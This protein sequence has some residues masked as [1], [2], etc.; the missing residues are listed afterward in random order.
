MYKVIKN[1]GKTVQ[2][3]QLGSDSSVIQELLRS[4]KIIP[5]DND[6]YEVFSQE[7]L[8]A[9]AEHG[10]I[11]SHGDWIKID[12]TGNPYPND[13]AFFEKNHR[14]VEGDTFEQIPQ[15]FWAWDAECAM[16]KE[17]EFLIREKGLHITPDSEEQ[18]YTAPLWGTVESAK[19]DAVIIFYS[20]SY[21]AAGNVMDADFNF[22]ERG[23]F[24]RTY[25]R[26]K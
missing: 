17:I 18:Y 19:K 13:Q 7:V 26:Y 25:S 6:K 5:L 9:G 14:Q 10:Q 4:R 24:E 15:P 11:A 22:V 1:H 16:C 20:I 3:Y 21:D 2:A 8:Q 23:E 12:S